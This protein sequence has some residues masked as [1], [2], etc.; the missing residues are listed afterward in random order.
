M[1]VCG[2]DGGNTCAIWR[3]QAK[4][5]G[6]Q[7]DGAQGRSG[8]RLNACVRIAGG[9]GGGGGGAECAGGRDRIWLTLCGRVCVWRKEGVANENGWTRCNYRREQKG[10]AH[11]KL[12]LESQYN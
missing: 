3:A 12:R 2:G 8:Q 10:Q 11:T 9:M 1:C 5:D 4:I 7:T 6:R